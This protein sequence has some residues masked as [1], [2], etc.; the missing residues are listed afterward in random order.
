MTKKINKNMKDYN[1]FIFSESSKNC[2]AHKIY[3][4]CADSNVGIIYCLKSST[5]SS[6][7]TILGITNNPTSDD[8]THRLIE[9][10]KSD[11]PEAYKENQDIINAYYTIRDISNLYINDSR[12]VDF[13]Q[14]FSKA[15]EVFNEF[16]GTLIVFDNFNDFAK[17]TA[18]KCK[19]CE[20]FDRTEFVKLCK[21]ETVDEDEFMSLTF[22]NGQCPLLIKWLC[23]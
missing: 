19:H 7:M 18:D 12:N 22:Q 13:E 21:A 11:Y 2:F 1:Y 9:N 23:S 3:L 15:L 4:R 17:Y 6:V 5:A 8:E 10:Y 16:F 14:A 20:N